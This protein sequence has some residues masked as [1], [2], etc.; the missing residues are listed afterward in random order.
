ML[1]LADRIMLNGVQ[2]KFYPTDETDKEG[3]VA[4]L[5]DGLRSQELPIIIADNI[6]EFVFPNGRNVRI[7]DLRQGCGRPP[8]IE[9]FIEWTAFGYKENK[10]AG[11]QGVY[12]VTVPKASNSNWPENVNASIRCF[13]LYNTNKESQRILAYH[14]IIDIIL[15]LNDEILGY[16]YSSPM[17]SVS[18]KD[19]EC[20]TSNLA[21]IVCYTLAFMNCK[22]VVIQDNTREYAQPAKWYRRTKVPQVSYHTINIQ[23]TTVRRNPNPISTDIQQR[24][25]ICRGHF[26]HYK[27]DGPGMFGRGVYGRFWVPQHQRGSSELGVVHS[28]YNVSPPGA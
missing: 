9:C 10:I 28:R 18:T 23:P 5:L 21:A 24:L 1:R 11:F 13:P 3:P 16:T 8:F 14:N 26:M 19:T 4:W 2:G 17:G 12:V 20:Y 7:H 22:N 25:H 15:G 6:N 27:E